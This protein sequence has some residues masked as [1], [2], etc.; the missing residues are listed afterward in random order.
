MD[1]MS[2][3]SRPVSEQAPRSPPPEVTVTNWPL[4]DDGPA[5]WVL[6]VAASAA[7]PLAAWLAGSAAMGWLVAAVLAVALWRLWL[8]VTY[9]FGYRG[10]TQSCLGRARLIPWRSLSRYEVYSGGVP[11]SADPDR[12][13]L[14]ALRSVFVCW[15]GKRAEIMAHVE[16][17][18]LPASR[19]PQN[20]RSTSTR[21]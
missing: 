2:T 16:Y 4:R 9:E 1:G 10:I 3:P 18:V 20:N 15:G 8:P 7:G 21:P 12:S 6:A 13:P 14:S 5:G 19:P 11:L 17:Y